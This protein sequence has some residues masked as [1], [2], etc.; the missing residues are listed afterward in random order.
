M[1]E[2]NNNKFF[3]KLK[4]KQ[5]IIS[6]IIGI[7]IGAGLILWIQSKKPKTVDA[8]PSSVSVVFERVVARNELV[9]A[10][11][12]YLDVEKA[13]N[14]R[15]VFGK[16][17]PLTQNSYWYRYVGTIKVA[18]DLSQAELLNKDEDSKELIIELN[19][20]YISSN[21]PDLNESKVLEE[22]NNLLNPITVK[23]TDA[24]RK[25]CIENI[26]KKAKKDGYLFEEAKENTET[27]LNDLFKMSLGDDYSVSIQWR[28]QKEK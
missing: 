20:P 13:E 11:Q 3:K 4:P 5:I 17:I 1:P 15:K 26:E 27:N 24:F 18:V 12:R 21:T 8:E 28:E 2:E 19:Q 23:M 16:S 9:A 7:L 14:P 25:K 22:T 6:L 10:S